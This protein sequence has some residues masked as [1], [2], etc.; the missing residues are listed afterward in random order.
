MTPVPPLARRNPVA[1]LG[2]A[3]LFA[4]PL[5]ATVDPLTPALALAVELT[6]I[7]F[8]GVRPSLLARRAWPLLIAAAGVLISML[9]FAADR[10]GD[11]LATAGPFDVTTGVLSGAAGLTL[12]IFAVALPGILVLATT[13]PTDLADA[14]VQN[15]RLP[16]RFAIGALAAFR[17]LPL[18]GQEWQTLSLARRARGLAPGP[19]L[20]L[21][22]AFALL[23]GALR[24]GVRLAVAM[25]ARGFDAG[26]PRTHARLQRFTT[27]D[28][29]LLI[30][31]VLL[32]AGILTTT[33]LLGLFRPITG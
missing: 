12:R 32:S 29:A 8:S 18:L 6:V 2:A 23:V 24:R 10:G 22:T 14:L 1:K 17:L 5:I 27:A 25:D 31:A 30:A 16:E 9:L 20:F 26:T 19:R 7:P 15:A 13:D 33:A 4:L 3:L 21:T 11:L 28:G